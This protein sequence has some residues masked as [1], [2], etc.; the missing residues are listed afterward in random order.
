MMIEMDEM[1]MTAP[2]M[3]KEDVKI[4]IYKQ[5]RQLLIYGGEV[6]VR[7]IP[8]HSGIEGNER[9]DKAAKEAAADSRTQVSRWS[10]LTH[11]KKKDNKRQ[12]LRNLPMAS[13]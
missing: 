6:I 8:S 5:A 11:V 12:K 4:Q 2:D 9:A 7:W 1:R 13:G 3:K 10:S